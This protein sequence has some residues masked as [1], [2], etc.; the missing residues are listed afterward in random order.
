MSNIYTV[1]KGT[2]SFIPE[3]IVKNSD[4]MNHSFYDSAT[5]EKFD[6]SN[7]VIIDKFQE[8]TKINERRVV[9]DN[10]R[11]SDLGYYASLDALE[12]SG[13]DK[14]ELEFIICS[15]N[16]GD[17]TAS[18]GQ[19]DTMPALANRIKHRLEIKNPY[20][21]C[22]D[23]V[24]GCPGWTTAMIVAD[25][26]IKSGIYKKGLVIGTDVN[27]RH[28]D[29]YD[30]DCMIFGDGAGATIVEGVES[31]TPIGIISHVSRSDS[32]ID[33]GML[34]LAPSLNK[35]HDQKDLY[36][37]MQGNRV[38]VY[39]LSNVPKTVKMSIDKAGIDISNIKKVL[40]HQA[41][42]KMDEA[43]LI[44]VF[45][46]YG[47]RTNDVSDVMPMTIGTL[48]NSSTAT[49]PTLL[50]YVTKGKMDNHAVKSGDHMILASVGAGMNINSIVY[51]IP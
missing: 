39:A 33:L 5:N 44:R 8:I 14:E 7:D 29:P 48:G 42:E 51:K 47:I 12:S 27:T 34:K 45:K 50:D 24:A 41:N 2:G 49:V 35:E 11:T 43:I 28:G 18:N 22:H 21:Y 26:Y 17:A 9:D 23:V 31:D 40:I 1:V 16:F 37:R 4:F 19:T 3:K 32:G 30:R 46:L 20:C 25:A 13:I 36:I 10:D 15:H 38:Y 6:R